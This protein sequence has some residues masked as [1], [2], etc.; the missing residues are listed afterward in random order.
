M[1]LPTRR[2]VLAIAAIIVLFAAGA[3]GYMEFSAD[4]PDGLEKTMEEAGVAESEPIYHAPLDYGDSYLEYLFM[5]L[6]GFAAI[7]LIVLITTKLMAS[8]D[9]A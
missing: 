4:K 2:Q 8:K 9:E 7:L 1:I 5:G 6:I 3:I